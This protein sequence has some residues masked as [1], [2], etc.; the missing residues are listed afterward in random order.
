[1]LSDRIKLLAASAAVALLAPVSAHANLI[2]NG[3]F[4]DTP[5]SFAWY[6]EYG[7]ALSPQQPNYGGLT[8]T[9]WTITTNNVDVVS[10]ATAPGGAAAADGVQYLDLVGTG[11]TGGISQ[12]FSTKVGQTYSLSFDYGN[13]PWITST[14]SALITVLLDGTSVSSNVTHDTS[15][16]TNI[17]WTPAGLSFVATTDQTTLSFLNTI[18]NGSGGVLLD[19][20]NVNPTPLPAALP[21]FAGG[22]AMIGLIG[23]KRRKTV[24]S[25]AAA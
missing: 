3:S 14:A 6:E 5:I 17:H 13:N 1:M 25:I 9:D 11:S 4:D 20:I 21:L 8:L 12:T 19:N 24:A 16:M 15:T 7:A 23:R 22:L 18:G 2:S 10:S